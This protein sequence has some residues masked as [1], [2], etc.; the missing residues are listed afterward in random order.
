MSKTIGRHFSKN[1]YKNNE[2]MKKCSTP[3]TIREIKKTSI[4]WMR[5]QKHSAQK[6]A[7]TFWLHSCEILQ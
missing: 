2:H 7:D 5:F 4:K 6:R 1:I 3:I